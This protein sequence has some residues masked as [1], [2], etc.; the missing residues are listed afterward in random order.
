MYENNKYVK[1]KCKD[2]INFT[3]I[4]TVA[5]FIIGIIVAVIVINLYH[6]IEINDFNN[7]IRTLTKDI[8]IALMGM[9]GFVI[10][11]LSIMTSAISNKVVKLIDKSGCFDKLIGIFSS[12]YFDGLIISITIIT[13]LFGYI[14]SFLKIPINKWILF[15]STFICSYLLCFIILYSV[16]LLKTCIEIFKISYKFSECHD[17]S[18][19]YEKNI[20]DIDHIRNLFNNHRINSMIN[21]LLKTD[22][23]KKEFLSELKKCI[24]LCSKGD[25]KQCLIDYYNKLYEYDE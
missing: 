17:M 25:E 9:L 21:V 2:I 13:Y 7:L 15:I 1:L 14:I 10:S 22:K 6:L 16:S 20:N 5:S 12:F 3:K 8:G 23:S 19:S 18:K 4:E 11:G 24:D